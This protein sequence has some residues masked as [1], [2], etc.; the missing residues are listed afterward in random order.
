[1]MQES[2]KPLWLFCINLLELR[3]KTVGQSARSSRRGKRWRAQRSLCAHPCWQRRCAGSRKGRVAGPGYGVWVKYVGPC[4]GCCFTH[5]SRGHVFVLIATR[6]SGS[7]TFLMPC[8]FKQTFLRSTVD[9]SYNADLNEFHR[10]AHHMKSSFQLVSFLK[11][12]RN[13]WPQDSHICLLQ[14]CTWEQLEG[15]QML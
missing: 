1:M 8:I 13:Q 14:A 5:P 10:L 12:I 2:Q 9:N 11:I 3:R 4:Q 6:V 7:S 15:P